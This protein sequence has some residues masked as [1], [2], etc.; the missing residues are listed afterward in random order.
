[1]TTKEVADAFTALCKAGKLDEAGMTF[2]AENVRSIEA[3]E[4]PQQVATGIPAL[5]AK[6][7]WWYGAHDVH[8]IEVHGPMMNGEQFALRFVMDVTFKETGAR[9]LLDEVALYTVANGKI[10]EER[11]FY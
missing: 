4:G 10:G 11:F 7:E 8:S 2:W 5:V 6:G 3:M 9:H 1:M